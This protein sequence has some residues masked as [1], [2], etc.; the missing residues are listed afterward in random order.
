MKIERKIRKRYDRKEPPQDY[1]KYW[2]VIRYWVRAVY[3]LTTPDLEMLLFL[4]SEQIFSKDKFSEFE[5]IMSWDKNRFERLRQEGWIIVWKKREGK[6]KALYEISH[7]GKKL[8]RIVYKKL[9]GEEIS[10]RNPLFLKG[11]SYMDKV[12]RNVIIEMNK[13]IKQQRHLS[14][15]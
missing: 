4:H 8:V 6:K 10:E 7:K 15:E 9:N 1:L 11:A 14:Q 2:R 13:T 3:G 5:E 12:Y